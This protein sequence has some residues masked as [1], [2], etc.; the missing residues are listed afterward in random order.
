[1][2]T[3][4]PVIDTLVESQTQFINNWMESAKKVQSAFTSGNIASE[5][6]S[7]FKEYFDKQ[8]NVLNSIREASATAVNGQESPQDFFPTGSTSRPVM[9]SRWQTLHRA[10]RA[11]S[12]A[13]ASRRR[14]TCRRSVSRIPLS[15]TFTTPGFTP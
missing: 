12:E 1:M 9:P 15:Q 13:S 8:T 4:N 7:L 10:F 11:V 5:G 14:T 6:Q 2:K 3:Y